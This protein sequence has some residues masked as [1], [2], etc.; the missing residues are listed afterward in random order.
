ML[1]LPAI[2]AILIDLDRASYMRGRS[3][4]QPESI[5]TSESTKLSSEIHLLPSLESISTGMMSNKQLTRQVCEHNVE[6]IFSQQMDYFQ[7]SISPV[8]CNLPHLTDFRHVAD[9]S[10]VGTLKVMR[11]DEVLPHETNQVRECS[12][13]VC[14][15]NHSSLCSHSKNVPCTSSRSY[16]VSGL[17]QTGAP[18]LRIVHTMGRP[19]TGPKVPVPSRS[20]SPVN[21]S[22]TRTMHV[23]FLAALLAPKALSVQ[24]TPPL[25]AEESYAAYLMAHRAAAKDSDDD[26]SCPQKRSLTG[27]HSVWARSGRSRSMA[28]RISVENLAG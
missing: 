25:K 19:L 21:A 18:E 27:A 2:P 8:S 16:G 23:N 4:W 22:S 20:S 10:C 11:N 15:N 3:L 7:T 28:S 13:S 1:S 14:W 24:P 5:K 26:A 17:Q 9:K 12:K 6:V